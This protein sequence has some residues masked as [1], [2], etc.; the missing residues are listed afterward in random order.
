MSLKSS[1]LH[2]NESGGG[3]GA[4]FSQG[5][6]LK[7][8][9]S[10]VFDNAAQDDGGAI[11]AAGGSV[12][13]H[14]TT[15][16]SNKAADDGGALRLKDVSL[17][18]SASA[19]GENA[20]VDLGGAIHSVTGTLRIENSAF[21]GNSAESGGAISSADEDA[22]LKH[23]TI[24]ANSANQFGGGL[25]AHGE[26]E[27]TPGRMFMQHSILADNA[28]GDC[29]VGAHGQI[30]DNSYT[31]IGDG[32]CMATIAGDAGL[33]ELAHPSDGGPA[34][35]PLLADSVAIDAGDPFLCLAVDQIGTARP[36]GDGCD[37]G[38]IEYAG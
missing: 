6:S 4:L 32:S 10:I 16:N 13:I 17:Q 18:V 30:V 34:Y 37:L 29:H 1:S 11:R 38:A 12:E 22:L 35:L 33:D 2:D 8:S 5:G 15:F 3:G 14:A 23:V 31:L 20:A 28:G 24:A 25:L 27:E 26:S 36:Q 21:Y 19:F 7:I 9:D